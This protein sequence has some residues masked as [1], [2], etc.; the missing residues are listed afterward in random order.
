MSNFKIAMGE[1][2]LATYL[3]LIL[4]DSLGLWAT[5]IGV[6]K[7]LMLCA[8]RNMYLI[9]KTYLYLFIFHRQ[10]GF[11]SGMST[12]NSFF[13][14]EFEEFVMDNVTCTGLENNLQECQYNHYLD[15]AQ[16]DGAG[17][18]CGNSRIC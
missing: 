12:I 1:S 15:Y 17:V 14:P 13:G 9:L 8:G 18:I 16:N 2:I 5:R 7:M 4:L 10:L 11:K 3:Q 6:M